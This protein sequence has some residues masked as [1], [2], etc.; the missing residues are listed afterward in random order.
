MCM[1]SWYGLSPSPDRLLP[2]EHV[3]NIP[4]ACETWI[5][6]WWSMAVFGCCLVCSE[7]TSCQRA[8]DFQSLWTGVSARYLAKVRLYP[9]L[10]RTIQKNSRRECSF[11][12]YLAWE[13]SVALWICYLMVSHQVCFFTFSNWD[14]TAYRLEFKVFWLWVMGSPWQL[15]WHRRRKTFWN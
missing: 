13:V 9:G 3:G 4:C 6:F 8:D 5:G 2:K 12:K 15:G 1:W 10:I 7:A 11:W 14:S